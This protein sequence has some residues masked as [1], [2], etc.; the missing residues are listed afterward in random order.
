MV[1]DCLSYLPM[2][3]CNLPVPALCHF[4]GGMQLDR[5]KD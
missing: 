3:M 5:V 2:E 1:I 4:D